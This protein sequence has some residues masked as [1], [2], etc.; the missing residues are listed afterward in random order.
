VIERAL[1]VIQGNRLQF[2]LSGKNVDTGIIAEEYTGEE[3]MKIPFTE[4]VRLACDRENILAALRRTNGK[5]S[6]EDGAAE[7]LGIKP[8]TLA[9]RM[10]ALGVEKP[11]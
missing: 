9:S 7:L 11:R 3:S 8:T 10:K 5:M 4:T 6:G 1:I 2:N